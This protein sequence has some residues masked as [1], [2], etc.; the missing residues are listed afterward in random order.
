VQ[1]LI[2]E[3]DGIFDVPKI[4]YKTGR[5]KIRPV[6]LKLFRKLNNFQINCLKIILF[7]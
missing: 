3:K 1:Y 7:L 5:M 4:H 6:Y 2:F